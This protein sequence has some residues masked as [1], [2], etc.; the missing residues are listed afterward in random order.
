MSRRG[1][2]NNILIVIAYACPEYGPDAAVKPALIDILLVAASRD[3]DSGDAERRRIS[4]VHLSTAKH[5]NVL[6]LDSTVTDT[7]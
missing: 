1:P 4:L 6:S 7:I 2:E 3:C 5:F